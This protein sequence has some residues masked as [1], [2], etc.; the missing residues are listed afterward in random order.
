MG[1]PRV[2]EDAERG[3]VPSSDHVVVRSTSRIEISLI[4]EDSGRATPKHRDCTTRKMSNHSVPNVL[5]CSSMTEIAVSR[6]R[7]SDFVHDRATKRLNVQEQLS[8]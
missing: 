4:F 6:E 8:R 5:L 1:Q 2:T 3:N 7:A